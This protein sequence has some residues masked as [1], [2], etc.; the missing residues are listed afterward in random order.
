MDDSAFRL[1]PRIERD[2]L[3]VC[4]LPLSSVQLMDERRYPWLIIVPRRA[5]ATDLFGLSP[6]DQRQLWLEMR[7]CAE[8]LRAECAPDRLNVGALG[9]VVAQLHVHIIGREPGDAAWP[10]PVW[11]AHPREARDPAESARL[12]ARLVARLRARLI[13]GAPG[14]EAADGGR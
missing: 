4:D 1:D 13:E 8:A 5:G 11:G 14:A 3:A 12:V 7:W 9:N 2:T 6:D 10:G